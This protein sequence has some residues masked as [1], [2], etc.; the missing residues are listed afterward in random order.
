MVRVERTATLSEPH[1]SFLER[2]SHCCQ[3]SALSRPCG[4]AGSPPVYI[5]EMSPFPAYGAAGGPGRPV[6]TAKP[7]AGP[8]GVAHC[9][10]YLSTGRAVAA[11]AQKVAAAKASLN[12]R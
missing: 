2:Y 1:M 5:T 7:P 6:G 10:V 8:G 4:G 3:L 9:T 11:M 12:I